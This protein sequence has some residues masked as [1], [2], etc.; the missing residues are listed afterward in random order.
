VVLPVKNLVPMGKKMEK[1]KRK[2]KN[3]IPHLLFHLVV[4]FETNNLIMVA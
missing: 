3:R 1:K 4:S 2:K